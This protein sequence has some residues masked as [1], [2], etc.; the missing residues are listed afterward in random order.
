VEIH[1]RFIAKEFPMLSPECLGELRTAWL[2]NITDAGLNRLIELLEKNSPLL[3]HGC[4]T[5]AIPMGC[6]ATHVA[7]HHPRTCHLTLDAGITWLHHVAGLNPATSHVVR[8]WDLRGVHDRELQADLLTF[9]RQARR[10]RRAETSRA[11]P[12]PVLQLV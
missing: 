8:E 2:P 4:F 9:F 10:A 3:I 12:D 1:R 7:W 5:R 11:K 6:L